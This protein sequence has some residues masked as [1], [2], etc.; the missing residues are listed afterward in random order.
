[1]CTPVNR[2]APYACQ[3]TFAKIYNSGGVDVLLHILYNTPP[4]DAIV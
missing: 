2:L 1:M 4:F 3:F